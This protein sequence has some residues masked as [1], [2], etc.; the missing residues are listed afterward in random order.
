[1]TVDELIEML[2]KHRRIMGGSHPVGSFA[3]EF[4]TWHEATK[5]EFEP[6]RPRNWPTNYS[7][8]VGG[9]VLIR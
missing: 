7:P 3:D 2:E 8:P 1:M 5:V 6:H 4:G 9:G